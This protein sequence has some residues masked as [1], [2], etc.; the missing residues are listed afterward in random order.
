MKPFESFLAPKLEEYIVYR[1]NI[2]Y[3]TKSLRS[4]LFTFDQYVKEKGNSRE[5]I[6]PAFFLELRAHFGHKPRTGN[7]LLSV[8]RSFFKYLV[9]KNDYE[10]NPVEGIPALPQQAF[11]PFVFS[12]EQTDQL[13]SAVVQRMRKNERYFLKDMS[14]YMAIVLIAR[15]GM[16][17][18]EP[19][20]LKPHHYRR[21]EGTLYIEK[22]KFR[23]DRL[24][25]LP[26]AAL[27]ELENFLALKKVLIGNNKTP[28]LLVGEKDNP[29]TT[30]EIYRLFHPSVKDIGIVSPREVI[31]DVT[32][33]PP[34]IHSLRH[35]FAINTLKRIR[36][37]G[38]SV[39]H[40]L[41][42]LAAYMGHCKYQ[43]TGAY[44]KV[45][46][47]DHRQGLIEFAKSQWD[48]V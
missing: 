24:I 25:P 41:P 14:I 30:E 5:S 39:Q 11:I 29:V 32:F 20:R 45:L 40:A 22:T 36:E 23:K 48:Y 21:K 2:G 42:V 43:Y 16:R 27:K 10:N 18:R 34:R 38:Q 8:I 3:E 31:G 37:R 1:R 47:A 13:L 35:S 7:T 12:P 46:S 19:L 44:L 33:G 17:L 6:Q 26:Q 15:C 9:R 4:T 28:Y